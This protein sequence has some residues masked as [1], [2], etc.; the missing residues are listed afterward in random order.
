MLGNWL[1]PV[2]ILWDIKCWHPNDILK[3]SVYSLYV[4]ET[5][6]PGFHL[7]GPQNR[8]VTKNTFRTFVRSF[9]SKILGGL[10]TSIK[11]ELV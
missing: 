6:E 9:N 11:V 8:Q 1:K 2:Q 4:L 7:Q 5:R 10:C 3:L